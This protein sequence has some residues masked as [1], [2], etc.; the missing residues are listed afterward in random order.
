VTRTSLRNFESGSGLMFQLIVEVENRGV[1]HVR[2]DELTNNYTIHD[3]SGGVLVGGPFIYVFPQVLEPGGFGYFVEGDRVYPSGTTADLVGEVELG[4]TSGM[5][6][7]PAAAYAV[8]DVL[9]SGGT[10]PEI[11]GAVTN[12]TPSDAI[13]GVVGVIL[14]GSAGQILGGMYDNTSIVTIA[15]GQARG[16]RAVYPPTPP[17]SEAE[18]G[19]WK[20]FAFDSVLPDS[21]TPATVSIE[22]APIGACFN[23]DVDPTSGGVAAVLVTCDGPHQHEKIGQEVLVAGPDADYPGVDAIEERSHGIC[24]PL[25]EAYVGMEPDASALTYWFL[26]PDE[27]AWVTGQRTVICTAGYG[28]RSM[29]PPGSV[30]DSGQQ[31]T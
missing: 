29:Q 28:D 31:T 8:S 10:L 13:T 3:T 24:R 25:F 23:E 15:A 5:A 18:V 22:N 12:G 7:G 27:A 17:I 2:I 19:C 6:P 1:G 21:S 14:F 16:F 9:V 11:S 20:A 26:A 30:R 4:I